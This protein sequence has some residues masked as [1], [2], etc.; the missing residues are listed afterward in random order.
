MAFRLWFL[1]F[2]DLRIALSLLMFLTGSSARPAPGTLVPAMRGR[3][4][5]SGSPI[6]S[7]QGKVVGVNIPLKRAGRLLLLEGTI[8]NVCGNFILDTGSSELALNS[9]YFRSSMT[10]DDE[11]GGGVTGATAGVARIHVKRLVISEWTYTNISA[12]VI[13]LGHLE[14]RRGVKI[15]GLFG[16]SLLKNLEVVLDIRNNELQIFKL[17]KTGRRLG[18]PSPVV[19][20]DVVQK[21]DESRNV[22]FVQAVIGGKLLDFCLDT[23]A[24]SNV[25]SIDANKKVL[26]TVT[27][28]RRSSLS[29]AG[30][31]RGEVLYGTLNDF[32]MGNRNMVPMETIV[33]SMAAMSQKYGYPVDGMLGYDFF[34]KG[35]FYINLVKKEM[36]IC[37]V[38]E[39]KK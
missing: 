24:E 4:S 26:A 37:L 27:I 31:N 21:I 1:S 30:E 36:S 32:S 19:K 28:T 9:T 29:G 14:N 35:K 23:G 15:L 16:M 2:V 11:E 38:P 18:P 5:I 10:F 7:Q 20:Y 3:I 34:A 6:L 8:D 12:D 25:L 13:P 33:C 22:V 17:D 39:E